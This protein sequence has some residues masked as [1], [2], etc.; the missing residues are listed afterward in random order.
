M[1]K[2]LKSN[3]IALPALAAVCCAG[4][5][6]CGAGGY[7]LTSPNAVCTL[8]AVLREISALAYVDPATLV[9]IEDELGILYTYNPE[10]SLITTQR[11]FSAEGDYEGIA[12]VAQTMYVL[13]SDGRL[14]EVAD[15]SSEAPQVRFYDTGVPSKDNEGLCYDEARHRLLI[16]AKSK[17]GKKAELKDKRM[18]Y[19]FDLK[20]M[21]LR[22]EPVFTLDPQEI[23]AFAQHA[24]IALPQQKKTKKGG[25]GA[26]PAVELRPSAIGVHPITGQLYLL[27][28]ASHLLLVLTMD[29][30][31]QD[32][33]VLDP[34]RFNKAEG[35]TF[36]GE[37]DLFISNEGEDGPAT[38]LRFDLQQK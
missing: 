17:S 6:A 36:T 9:C 21:R 7:D 11:T 15:Y 32:I 33:E 10:T 29:G 14:F 4:P 26:P 13:R 28:A 23:T 25:T 30:T 18:I 27:S 35:I 12:R 1:L 34:K 19:E 37:G 16:A 20:T 22:E 8:P 5:E 3:T 2:R 38:I 24:G 31:I